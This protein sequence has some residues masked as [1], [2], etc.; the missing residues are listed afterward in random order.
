[1]SGPNPSISITSIVLTGFM[2]AGKTTAGALLAERLGWRFADSD[3]LV[4][5][6]AGTS[7]AEI[8]ERRGEAAFRALEADVIT[9]AITGAEGGTGV[10][11]ALG[12]GALESAATRDFLAAQAGIRIVFLD[13]PLDTLLE[14]CAGQANAPVR[15]VLRDREGLAARWE[16]RQPMYRQ[17]HWTVATAG[18][19]AEEVAACIVKEFFSPPAAGDAVEPMCDAAGGGSR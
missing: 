10:V 4:E 11:L 17:A 12:G 18:R 6:R 7:V 15:P 14:R 3:H 5:K 8:F 1:M 19:S 2:G 9:E 13:A 16:A